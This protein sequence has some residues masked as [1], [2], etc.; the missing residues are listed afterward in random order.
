MSKAS[1]AVCHPRMGFGGSEAAAMWT[2]EALKRDYRVA[3]I[4]GGRIDL[5]A[6]N[7]FCGTAVESGEC[8]I[9]EIPLPWPLSKANWGAALRGAFVSRGMRTYFDRFDL[10]ISSYNIGSFGRPGIHLLADFSW[11]ER[12]RRQLDS[13]SS[14]AGALAGVKGSLRNLHLAL[15]KAISGP[16]AHRN[17]GDLGIVFANSR[18]TAEVLGPRYA[19]D[20]K[21]LYPPVTMREPGAFC[22]PRRRRFV[23]VGRIS[24]E[25]R[26]EQMIGI[27]R[28]VRARGHDIALHIIGAT[29]ETTYGRMIERMCRSEGSWI[30]LEGRRFGASKTRLLAESAFGIHAR[31]CEA[32][33]IAVAEMI[34]VGCVPFVPAEGG[35]AEIVNYNPAIVYSSPEDGIEKIDAM[36]RNSTLERDTRALLLKRACLFSCES[37]IRGIRTAVGSFIDRQ[38]L[39]DGVAGL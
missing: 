8:E 28:A 39:G 22:G 21:L 11:D 4:A 2:L 3:L 30:V 37:F 13:T 7:S 35:P 27:L 38:R 1:I 14:S 17:S 33:G 23:C 19:I 34:T 12:L 6:L 9:L 16:A 36:L 18:W 15:A 24:P 32:F 5:G 29:R 31:A 10:L 20:A 25:K 26:I